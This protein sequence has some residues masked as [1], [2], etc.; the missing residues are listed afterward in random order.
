MNIFGIGVVFLNHY[1]DRLLGYFLNS[2]L[3][4]GM[5]NSN[6][7]PLGIKEKYGDKTKDEEADHL[8]DLNKDKIIPLLT[9]FINKLD[10][11]TETMRYQDDYSKTL[12]V[13]S[14]GV[15]GEYTMIKDKVIH[16][17]LVKK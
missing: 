17:L 12:S 6:G 15:V 9:K 8:F 3:P 14:D 11:M 1:P 4:T 5:D 10:S 7:F 13:Q 2:S 16:C